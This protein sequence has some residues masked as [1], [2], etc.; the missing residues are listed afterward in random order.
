MPSSSKNMVFVLGVLLYSCHLFV[1]LFN[2]PWNFTKTSHELY[3]FLLHYI[4]FN[5]HTQTMRIFPDL[6]VY[7]VFVHNAAP[8]H[9]SE[10]FPFPVTISISIF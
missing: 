4:I 7:V 9:Y 6:F 1:S 3:I 5:Y 2:I 10:I 8:N